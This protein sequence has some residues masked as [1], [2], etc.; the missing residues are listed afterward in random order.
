[1][2]N[3]RERLARI[4][5]RRSVREY[6]MN[7]RQLILQIPDVS[8]AEALDKYKRGLKPAVRVLV[9][10][11]SPVTWEDAAVKAES[12]DSIQF[13]GRS[14]FQPSSRLA[15]RAAP[16]D[17][18]TPMEIG[19]I[20]STPRSTP[21]AD[22]F[23]KQQQREEDTRKGQCFYCHK[24]GHLAAACPDLGRDSSRASSSNN[25]RRKPDAS[26]Q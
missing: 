25:W 2:L 3:A 23:R 21:R 6:T 12:V 20:A 18:P 17:G 7:F 19:A 13:L 4:T 10:L 9:E 16:A 22:S 14:T 5:Q 11:A 1:M 26:R 15:P 8:P 24:T